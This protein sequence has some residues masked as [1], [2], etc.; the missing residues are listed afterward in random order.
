MAGRRRLKQFL[1]AEIESL[2]DAA[3]PDKELLNV[4]SEMWLEFFGVAR[5]PE[6]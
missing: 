2:E 3:E 1:L 6:T 5:S 4:P